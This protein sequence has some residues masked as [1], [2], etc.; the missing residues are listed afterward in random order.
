MHLEKLS[1]EVLSSERWLAC[2]LSIHSPICDTHNIECQLNNVMVDYNGCSLVSWI[3]AALTEIFFLCVCDSQQYRSWL[4]KWC[5]K[6]A[7]LGLL[8][9][10]VLPQSD[11]L[12][13]LSQG[14]P[15]RNELRMLFFYAFSMQMGAGLACKIRNS[16]AVKDFTAKRTEK[17]RSG[18]RE[19]EM[20]FRGGWETERK[21]QRQ[22]ERETACST[23]CLKNTF[24]GKE[25][26]RNKIRLK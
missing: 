11:V 10:S 17:P 3:A 20:D 9:C 23:G 8:F 15:A 21:R 14:G 18:G 24:L 22:T 5:L 25:K 4:W 16:A 13:E 6:C 26:W 2:D 19:G 12:K 1:M 7:C